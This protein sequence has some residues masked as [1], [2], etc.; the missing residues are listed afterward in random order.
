MKRKYESYKI[1]LCIA[2]KNDMQFSDL[3]NVSCVNFHVNLRVIIFTLR[4][5][6]KNKIQTQ[7][8]LIEINQSIK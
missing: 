3:E 4:V 5:E 6:N 2:T 8:P 1:I 7:D